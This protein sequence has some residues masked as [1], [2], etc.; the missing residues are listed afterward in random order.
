[1]QL[2]AVLVLAAAEVPRNEL[3]SM[4]VQTA[5]DES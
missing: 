4:V 5:R 1:M 2:S 3:A